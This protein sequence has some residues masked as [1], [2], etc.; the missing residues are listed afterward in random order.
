VCLRV[1]VC[2]CVQQMKSLK[3]QGKQVR[4]CVGGCVDGFLCGG[5]CVNVYGCVGVCM[6]MFVHAADVCVQQMK[7][8]KMQGKQIGVWYDCGCVRV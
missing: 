7:S 1:G 6:C 8:L 4:E 3:M 5:V 2:V